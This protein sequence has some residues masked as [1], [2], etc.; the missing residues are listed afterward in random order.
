MSKKKKNKQ[1]RDS[2]KGWDD[3]TPEEQMH[4]ADEFFNIDEDSAE[5][6][7]G[8]GISDKVLVDKETG[9]ESDIVNDIRKS[10]GVTEEVDIETKEP[11]EEVDGI[12][13]DQDLFEDL[14]DVGIP[15][16]VTDTVEE[17][18]EEVKETFPDVSF[19][20]DD[21]D[22]GYVFPT[23][24]TEEPKEEVKDTPVEED[25]EQF[26]DHYQP[27]DEEPEKDADYY[28]DIRKFGCIVR[29]TIGITTFNDGIAP[30][31]IN[32]HVAQLEGLSKNIDESTID[33]NIIKLFKN[34]LIVNRFPA[35]LYTHDEFVSL[36]GRGKFVQQDLEQ[37]VFV[38]VLNEYIA[39]YFVHDGALQRFNDTISEIIT[40]DDVEEYGNP[41]YNVWI[42]LATILDSDDHSFFA[43]EGNVELFYNSTHNDKEIVKEYLRDKYI[44]TSVDEEV[45]VNIVNRDKVESAF[46]YVMDEIID[47]DLDEDDDD[48]EEIEETPVEEA[49]VVSGHEA[50]AK[51]IA[52]NAEKNLEAKKDDSMVIPVH[53]KEGK[54]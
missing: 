40:V 4:N 19:E 15:E 48:D 35:A 49:P 42:Y 16:E 43:E 32:E 36:L 14:E 17:P 46:S 37:A 12:M 22:E 9:L 33:D 38:D 11:E 18:K 24:K 44:D 28:V 13:E 53:H 39:V 2:F 25:M 54:K 8:L 41:Y 5:D 21:D 47:I 29:K 26:T 30:F 34:A 3:M 10:F 6:V 7:L 23:T 1:I 31:A 27:E 20:D 50:L 51:A 52:A 45:V